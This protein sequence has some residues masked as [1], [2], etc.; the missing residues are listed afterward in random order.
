MVK[1]THRPSLV[2]GSAQAARICT[3]TPATG[4]ARGGLI[5]P[6]PGASR[7]SR[8]T[9]AKTPA[10]ATAMV[11]KAAVQPWLCRA[12]ARTTVVTRLPT[13]PTRPVSWATSGLRA[14]GNQWAETRSTL[15]KVMASPQPMTAREASA[16]PKVVARAKASC[17]ALISR[18][19]SSRTRL[20]PKRSTR[21]PTG[22]CM[23]AYTSTCSTA[24]VESA[25]APIPKRAAAS[26]PATPRL[27]RW[28][29][30]SR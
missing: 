28:T 17:P 5:R 23:A 30:A 27:V 11:A 14:A 21:R 13:T 25:E 26:S 3:P 1:C 7:S 19:P 8:A 9:R 6:W 18:T 12:R 10:P 24:K 20:A 2:P 15:M 22:I 29:T 16:G 4:A